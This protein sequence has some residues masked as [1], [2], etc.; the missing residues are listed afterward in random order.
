MAQLLSTLFE[1]GTFSPIELTAA[2]EVI[3]YV[4]QPLGAMG[5]AL[6][7]T[8]NVS[9]RSVAVAKR[10]NRYELIP[11]SPIGAPPVELELK[12]TDIRTFKTTRL[13]KGSTVYAE[14]V[15]G[16]L[17]A[18]TFTA[19]RGL[20]EEVAMRA[21]KI[22]EDMDLTQENM[23]FST[24]MGVLKDADGSTLLDYYSE[25]GVSAPTPIDFELGTAT[26][27]VRGK[28]ETVIQ[29]MLVAGKGGFVPGRTEVHALCGWTFFDDL[30]THPMVERYWLNQS[31]ALDLIGM[32]P[33]IFRF[34]GI[35][36][37]KYR[38][39]D[40]GTL[41]AIDDEVARFFPVGGQDVFQR[42]FGPAEFSPFVNS[43]G[44]EIYALTI[45]D[46]DRGAW[47]RIEAYSYPLYI[48]LRPAMLQ[49]GWANGAP[50]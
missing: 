45:P 48:C 38:N 19:L 47:Q 11:T 10:T 8:V 46:R 3:D 25:W 39:S 43:P 37:H 33:D 1:A 44:Q 26:T 15:Q 2:F 28:C 35:T 18:P 40:I 32:Q 29:T 5:E 9:T 30:I 27:S 12:P 7:P 41:M 14:S 49:I 17:V 21:V 34:G 20:Q 6:F 31:A 22:R 23:R 24:L 42:V 36:F 50:T 4:P 16:L 13:A